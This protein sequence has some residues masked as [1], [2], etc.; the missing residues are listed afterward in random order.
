MKL[1][2][3]ILFLISITYLQ[4]AFAND[5]CNCKGYAGPGGPCYSGPGG[6]C[7]AGPG[8]PYYAGPGGPKYNG[9]GGPEY[10][11]P[12]GPKYSG[13]GGPAYA[14]PGGPCYAGPGGPCYSGPGG[15]NN[16]PSICE[17]RNKMT[18]HR[19]IRENI[20]RAVARAREDGINIDDESYRE[21]DFFLRIYIKIGGR[22]TLR[23][24]SFE[25]QYTSLE[26]VTEDDILKEIQRIARRAS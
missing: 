14:G 11:G 23:T 16:C 3:Q 20:Q 9:P 15:G 2:L 1:I 6:P 24:E 10:D 25:G 17:G 21:D 26:D 22:N 7:Y 5:S 13:P 12:G 19:E 4:P 18:T 8:G